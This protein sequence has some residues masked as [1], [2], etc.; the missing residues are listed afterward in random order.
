H[1]ASVD[2]LM[3]SR[4]YPDSQPSPHGRRPIRTGPIAYVASRAAEVVDA[5]LTGGDAGASRA[6]AG[7][8]GTGKR[9]K[10]A[11]ACT[12]DGGGDIRATR[13]E[14]GDHGQQ[15]PTICDGILRRPRRRRAGATEAAPAP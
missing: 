14:R 9:R 13:G 5:A 1:G 7:T 15:F 11:R 10:Y 8:P 3:D 6:E 12:F 2:G 4:V